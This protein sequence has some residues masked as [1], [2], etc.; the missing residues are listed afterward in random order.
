[1]TSC[2]TVPT[3]AGSLACRWAVIYW[4]GPVIW[5]LDDLGILPPQ[6]TTGVRQEVST[7]MPMWGYYAPGGMVWWMILSS[8]FWL[9][10]AAVAVW[11][12]VRWLSREAQWTANRP[13]EPTQQTALDIL[14]A[15][16]ARGEID[17]A[18]FQTMRAQIAATSA[19]SART[20]QEA[21][22]SGR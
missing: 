18:T 1:P 11:A 10:L 9:G 21:A 20:S 5:L 13:Q 8:L 12:L 14:K 16:Y 3:K 15:R 17:T 22:P 19:T 7:D 6:G 4:H 2:R